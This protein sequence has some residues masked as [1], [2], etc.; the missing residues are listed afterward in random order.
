M[1]KFPYKGINKTF[2]V[3]LTLS[4][5]LAPA[6]LAPAIA[7]NQPVEFL[8]YFN[9]LPEKGYVNQK[10]DRVIKK[11]SFKAA[12]MPAFDA[13][14]NKELGLFAEVTQKEAQDQNFVDELLAKPY[15]NGLSIYFSWQ[16]LEP[17]EDTFN[18]AELDRLLGVCAKYNKT[19]ILRVSTSGMDQ[20]K[21]VISDT[22]K[23]VLDKGIKSIK[24]MGADQQAHVMPVYWDTDYLADWSNFIQELGSRYDKNPNI[25]SIGITGGGALGGTALVPPLGIP[26]A[27]TQ[28]VIN[29]MVKPKAG[30]APGDDSTDDNASAAKA[31]EAKADDAKADDTKTANAKPETTADAKS[32]AKAE[33]TPDNP[34]AY[35]SQLTEK[36]KKEFGMNARQIAQHWKYVGDLFV[37]AFPTARLN[38]ALNA[39]L[40]HSAGQN[41]LDEISDYMIFRYG[42]RIFLTRQDVKNDKHGF[43]EYRIFLKWKADTLTGLK[44]SANLSAEEL[45][46]IAKFAFDDGNSYVEMP[47]ATILSKDEAISKTLSALASHLG[48][49]LVLQKATIPDSVPQ[50]Q[51]I[52]ASF[53]FLNVG[54]TVPLKP[55]RQLDKDVPVSYRMQV[56]LRDGTGK[57]VV[58]SLHTPK[59]STT[60]WK[61]GTPVTWEEELKMPDLQPGEYSVFM[62]LVDAE[63]NRRLQVIDAVSQQTPS[64]QSIVPIGK[65]KVVPATQS[66]GSTAPQA[67]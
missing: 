8:K 32:E 6:F 15:V 21:D 61:A 47:A 60:L 53:T 24:Y 44:L 36:F 42:Q 12:N 56:E 39:P 48:Y 65:I 4:S 59:T 58:V 9:P 66:I 34:K 14:N 50:G 64:G 17:Q 62:S 30:A 43:D 13:V 22:P 41:A 35:S 29:K 46:K 67:Q 31:D 7:K 33:D 2:V 51:P 27:D 40:T 20:S 45:T 38:F 3:G 16:Q 37:K 63:A 18:F 11:K 1:S 57:P 23:W 25:H 19:L 28:V 5:I 54:D 26:D 52:K 10:Q 55:S 49:Q